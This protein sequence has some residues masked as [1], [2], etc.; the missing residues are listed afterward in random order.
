MGS[1]VFQKTTITLE[2][3]K[4]FIVEAKNNSKENVYIQSAT[5]NGKSFDQN[6]ITYADIIN[7][8]T[9][10]LVMDSK[11]E[12]KRGVAENSKPFSLSNK[13]YEQKTIYP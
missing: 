10:Q 8:G 6:W 7:G 1:P 11:P 13:K 9:L 4:K 5:L 12:L 3:G 2:N